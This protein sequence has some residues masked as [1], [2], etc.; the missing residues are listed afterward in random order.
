MKLGDAGLFDRCRTESVPTLVMANM[1]IHI[2]LRDMVLRCEFGAALARPTRRNCTCHHTFIT[3]GVETASS[4]STRER[5]T[6]D[7]RIITDNADEK[8]FNILEATQLPRERESTETVAPPIGSPLPG[9]K[10]TVPP[11]A[12]VTP[13]DVSMLASWL[14]RMKQSGD[15]VC[16]TGAGLST[17]SG[18]PDYRSPNGAYS[19]GFKPMTHQVG[20]YERAPRLAYL[21]LFHSLL[22]LELSRPDAHAHAHAHSL[23]HPR[24]VPPL[25]TQDFM[26]TGS[27][28]A[29]NRKKYWIRSFAGWSS[30]SGM[31]PN[32]GHVAL[33][34]LQ[35]AGYVSQIITQNVDRLHHKAGSSE[36]AVLEL[37]GTTHQVRCMDCDTVYPRDDVQSLI[38]RMN[39]GA[40][41]EDGTIGLGNLGIAATLGVTETGKG[42]GAGSGERRR[43]AA[44]A[45]GPR[46]NPDGDVEIRD[47]EK[48]EFRTPVCPACRGGLLKPDV[49]FFGDSLPKERTDES[50]AVAKRA[51]GILVVGSS[52]QVMS[53]F[54][55]VQQAKELAGAEVFIVTIGETRADALADHKVSKLA[56]E[57][58]PLVVDAMRSRSSRQ[59]CKDLDCT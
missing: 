8:E 35:R 46:Q 37:H 43:R 25:R 2:A 15:V 17:E 32:S 58:L 55:L 52:L 11:A 47:T 6:G 30:F 13:E 23:A 40:L 38:V 50:L 44:R 49:V 59:G 39:G 26:R 24:L 41:N 7:G 42:D 33:A 29:Q 27:E 16:I 14:A 22:S 3:R 53:A 54:R 57:L 9:A 12:P 1:R 19:A 31:E 34:Q 4:R 28:G 21:L 48:V 51:A 56:G 20:S 45:A 36:V 10:N 5:I 18:I